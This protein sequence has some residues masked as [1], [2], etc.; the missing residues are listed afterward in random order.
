M[1][2]AEQVL[3]VARAELGVVEGPG[4]N[5]VKYNTWFYGGP[6]KGDNYAWC[7]VFVSW[8]AANSGAVDLFPRSGYCPSVVAAWKAK[9][10]WGTTPRVGAQVVFEWPSMGRPC[11]T[12]I[13]ESV[14]PDG[15][16]VT[17]EGNTDVAG[18][19]T[20][21]RVMRQVRRANIVGY[22]YPAYENAPRPPAA[23]RGLAVDG[24]FGPDT[25]R[26]LQA[27]VG[28]RQDGEY[29]PDTKHA[30]QRWLGVSADGV[31][32]PK[33]IRALQQR[34]GARVDGVWGPDTVRHLQSYLN[35][36]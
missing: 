5:N 19:R 25:C 1:T 21:G 6:V 7:A 14:R 16:V 35:S 31:V 17:I 10:Q 33:T 3:A 34:C 8:V 20:G 28:V 2:T 32:G 27:V 18:G 15:S 12:G 4:S 22:G 30:L 26:R 13:V 29:G 24:E 36:H 9:G 23:P 11:H